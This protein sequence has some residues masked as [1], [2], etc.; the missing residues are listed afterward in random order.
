M[1]KWQV[2]RSHHANHPQPEHAPLYTAH[3]PN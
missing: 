2:K 1:S 3:S